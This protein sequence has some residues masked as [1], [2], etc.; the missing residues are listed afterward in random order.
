MPAN[1]KKVLIIT[2]YWP[3]AG[4]S[5][6][7]RWVKF[8]KYLRDF[9]WEPVIYTPENAD[10]PLVDK[11]MGEELPS[12]LEIL[13]RPIW[14][15]YQLAS[16][17]TRQ[18]KEHRAGFIDKEGKRS[19]LQRFA[20]YIRANWFV[21]DARKFWIR[22]S[23]RFLKQYLQEH[24]VAAIVSTGPPHSMHLIAEGVHEQTDIP[25]LA[26]FRDPWKSIYYLHRLP[27][28]S[29][30]QQK[31]LKLERAVVQKA[32]LVTTV[33]HSIAEELGAHGKTVEVI[34]NGHD[35]PT[36]DE[37]IPL[38]K[39]FS[40]V[41]AGIM[42]GDQ[43]PEG[44]WQVIA[45]LVKENVQFKEKLRIKLVGVVSDEVMASLE[46][47]QLQSFLELPGYVSHEKVY[48]YQTKA[49]LLLL[50]I[51]KVPNAKGIITGKLFEYLAVNRPILAIGPADGDLATILNGSGGGTILEH[52][53][54]E[55]M[56]QFLE[57][58]FQKYQQGKLL[59]T[60]KDVSQYS[61]R[62]LT[63]QLAKLLDS[64]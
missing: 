58:A 51:N 35:L 11:R 22:P 8:A 6:V 61:R 63:R 31:H 21:P 41:H 48:E 7:Q 26:D 19:W 49:Q 3:P 34:Y 59:G 25:W 47:H 57:V 14:E 30:T 5:G 13:R 12:D 62:T 60:T 2:Y 36:P 44:L 40:I 1:R 55:G 38:D 9:G 16:W 43:D 45:E 53:D 56:K 15:P 46:K 18:Q 64:L 33:S 24:P 54:T 42:N 20:L 32:N 4:G 52:K 23:I 29:K 39:H 17:F 10:Y 28:T 37:S 50:S 27:L